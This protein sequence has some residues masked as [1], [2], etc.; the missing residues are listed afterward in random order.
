MLAAAYLFVLHVGLEKRLAAELRAAEG[1]R[2]IAVARVATAY[3]HNHEGEWPP[4]DPLRRFA[5]PPEEVPPGYAVAKPPEKDVV[6]PI[7]ALLLGR[8]GRH[9]V[10]NLQSIWEPDEFYYL[11]YATTNEAEGLALAEA[12]HSSIPLRDTITV[13]E[14]K[15]TLGGAKLYRLHN[16]LLETLATDGV[17]SEEQPELRRKIPVLI[18]RPAEGY[19]WVVYLDLHAEYL[20]YPGPYPLTKPFIDAIE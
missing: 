5:Y 4:L 2:A 17:L 11:G 3:A 13:P 20:P 9:S 6:V 19:A 7:A 15:G 18:Q 14:G 16:D 10:L 12:L 1:N 8:M